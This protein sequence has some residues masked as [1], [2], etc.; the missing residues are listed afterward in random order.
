[1]E[2]AKI[3][4]QLLALGVKGVAPERATPEFLAQLSPTRSRGG[5]ADQVLG[6]AGRLKQHVIGPA[7]WWHSWY[8]A[9]N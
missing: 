3:K 9:P 2:T 4:D 6:S 7:R 1:M 5:K 8:E